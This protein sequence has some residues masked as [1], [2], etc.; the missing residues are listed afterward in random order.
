MI[1]PDGAIAGING[2]FYDITDTGAPLG[3][4]VDRR[5]ACCTP[6]STAGTAP[7]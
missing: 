4:G 1:A 7:S 6:G 2:D 5:A 3:L